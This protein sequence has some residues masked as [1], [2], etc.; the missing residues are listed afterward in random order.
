M[1]SA[2]RANGPARRWHVRRRAVKPGPR[3]PI[4]A[5][6]APRFARTLSAPAKPRLRKRRPR[7]LVGRL[8]RRRVWERAR[9]AHTRR[10]PPR[11]RAKRA[12]DRRNPT[13]AASY[14]R[15]WAL[16]AP[17]PSASLA[18]GL[19]CF[20]KARNVDIRIVDIAV[21]F[22]NT[23]AQACVLRHFLDG[24]DCGPDKQR[25]VIGRHTPIPLWRF[26]AIKRCP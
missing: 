19:H 24:R 5:P 22:D 20:A 14:G 10:N 9:R 3:R 25:F 4:R 13:A 7:R 2:A 11:V 16:Y 12:W 26:D 21:A 17:L 23:N 15:V 1:S 18:N 6:D 8:A